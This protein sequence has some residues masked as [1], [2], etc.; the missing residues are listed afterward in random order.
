MLQRSTLMT[1]SLVVNYLPVGRQRSRDIET[2]LDGGMAGNT[3]ARVDGLMSVTLTQ[4][5]KSSA[6]VTGKLLATE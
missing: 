2:V 3:R 6:R 4:T 5:R 1:R